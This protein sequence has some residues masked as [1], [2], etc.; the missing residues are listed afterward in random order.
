MS[1]EADQRAAELSDPDPRTRSR[2][3]RELLRLGDARA[4]DACLRTLDDDPD[5]GHNE[6]TPSVACLIQI[7]RP[8]IVPAIEKLSAPGIATRARA[9]R[10]VQQITKRSFGFDG[11]H[12]SDADRD[13]WSAWWTAIGYQHDAEDTERAAAISRLRAAVSALP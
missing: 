6:R 11:D 5:P 9:Q 1:S 7:G 4:L 12:W 8:A 3:A 2:A 10:V 13:R